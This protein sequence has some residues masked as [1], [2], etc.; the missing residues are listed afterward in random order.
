VEGNEAKS[1]AGEPEKLNSLGTISVKLQFVR[2]VRSSRGEI[3]DT[4]SETLGTILEK[5]LKGQAMSHFTG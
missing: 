5:D 3:K 4:K 1:K 2:N